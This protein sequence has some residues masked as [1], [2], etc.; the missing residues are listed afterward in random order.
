MRNIINKISVLGFAMILIGLSSCTDLQELN[1]D[2]NNP[3]DV[4]AVNLV[5][6]AQYSLYANQHSRVLNAEW[7]ML[8]VQH[9]AQNEY[10]EES[11]YLV[12]ANSFDGLWTS[13]YASVLNE[14]TVAKDKITNDENL[15]GARKTNQLAIVNILIADAFHTVTDLWGA[16]PFSEALSKD[17]PN[18]SYDSQE[19]IYNSIL[20]SLD[21]A[22]GSIDVNGSSFDQGDI[23]LNG[24]IA[25]WKK[26]GA[27][28]LMRM[29]MR[30]SD[31]APGV[32]SEYVGKAVA[33]GVLESSAD[34]MLFKFDA[35]PALSNPLYIDNVLNTRDDFAVSKVL[36]DKLAELGDPRVE[37]FAALNN[38]MVYNG[39]P[40]GLTDA[41][42]FALKSVTSRPSAG[43]RD[44]LA[45][46][47]IIDFAEISFLM[48]EAVE[49]GMMS[50]DAAAF[51]N[52]GITA[53]MNYW[54]YTEVDDY[55]NAN[56]YTDGTW[57]E[58]IG[59]Q[60][61]IAFYMNGPQAWAEQRRL[62]QPVLDVPEAASISTIPVRLP[63]P[64]S[65]DTNN[66]SQ[67]DAVTSNIN[68]LTGKLWWD[69]N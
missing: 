63:Y 10:A 42:A 50:G 54:G 66:G 15:I 43:V 55:I 26:L 35:D 1:I 52:A 44:A 29:A 17:F 13:F 23:I 57:K 38:D 31:V 33:H 19:T 14:L 61:W 12:D 6:Q 48:A 18:P 25:G 16:A 49:R 37:A 67:L 21:A 3:T 20:A 47:V 41:E 46:H 60:K 27:S 51:Y 11:R 39:M 8:M 34:N 68:D 69:V 40:Y 45:P 9:W 62:D 56:P 36:V 24:D 65:E 64:I 30:V 7:G 4:P 28:L 2:P 5:T 32:A 59:L 53:S 22:V 58:V